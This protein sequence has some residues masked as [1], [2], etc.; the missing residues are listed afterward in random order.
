M[1]LNKFFVSKNISKKYI[2][3]DVK[4]S[5]DEK[6][7]IN[8]GRHLCIEVKSFH[9]ARINNQSHENS[10]MSTKIKRL[11]LMSTTQALCDTKL[12]MKK[13]FLR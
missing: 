3:H 5:D 2:P 12:I 9:D 7:K 10:I 13:L 8:R 4:C 1:N 11:L 6:E